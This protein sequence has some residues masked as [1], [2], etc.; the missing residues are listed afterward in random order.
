VKEEPNDFTKDI[1]KRPDTNS[2]QNEVS[3][4][5]HGLFHHS[6]AIIKARLKST[7]LKNSIGNDSELCDGNHRI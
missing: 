5:F 1:D 6:S 2:E 4:Q 7:K 3:E